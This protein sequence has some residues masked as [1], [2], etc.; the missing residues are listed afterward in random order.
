MKQI[1]SIFK[2]ATVDELYLYVKKAERFDRVPEALLEKFG[3]AVPV[4]DLLLY[5]GKKL[6]RV[7]V[8]RIMNALEEQ[9]Y[10]LQLPP[11]KEEYLLDLF[12]DTSY[13]YRDDI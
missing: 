5:P 4:F 12:R 9:G 10:Y 11:A 13:K 2:S 1:V 7:P 3:R 6:S 8:E